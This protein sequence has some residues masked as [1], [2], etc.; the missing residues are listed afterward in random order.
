MAEA[1][2]LAHV[3]RPL[4]LAR[5]LDRQRYDRA[6]SGGTGSRQA[7]VRRRHAAAV[8]RRRFAPAARP[9][10]RRR[11]RRLPAV[12]VGQR[13][14]GRRAVRERDQRLL[15]S[16]R[17]AA[18]PGAGAAD[19][20]AAAAGAGGPAVPPGAAA[21]VRAAQRAPQSRAQRAR[22]TVA[23]RRPAARVHR[24]RPRAVCRHPADVPGQ[25][26]ARHARVHG[27]SALVARH[28]VAAMVAGL[29]GGPAAG[30]RDAGQ[31]G[32]WRRAAA[33]TAGAGVAAGA[34]DRGHGRRRQSRRDSRQCPR[35]RLL[36]RHGRR[37]A[38]ATGDLQRRQS[39]QPAGAG[40]RRAGT[41]HRRQSG[42]VP[43]HG[44]RAC[45][46]GRAAVAVG[47]AERAG[48]AP[49]AAGTASGCCFGPPLAPAPQRQPGKAQAHDGQRG[50]FR[51]GQRGKRLRRI[52][53]Q[54]R[55]R[56]GRGAIPHHGRCKERRHVGGARHL[57][58]ENGAGHDV[59]VVGVDVI[60]HEARIERAGADAA[61]RREAGVV[62]HQVA[63]QDDDAVA[64]GVAGRRAA[65]G[66]RGAGAV[67]GHGAVAVAGHGLAAARAGRDLVEI[68]GQVLHAGAD[69]ID[70]HRCRLRGRQREVG[71]GGRLGIDQL[72][73]AH[74][75]ADLE[76]LIEAGWRDDG[77][78]IAVGHSANHHLRAQF[79]EIGRGAAGAA[80]GQAGDEAGG[81][82]GVGDVGPQI[83][84]DAVVAGTGDIQADRG[85]GAGGERG[86]QR[87]RYQG[88]G[89]RGFV[90]FHV[91]SQSRR[92]SCAQPPRRH[93]APHFAGADHR[94]LDDHGTGGHDGIVADA[95]ARHDHGR[96]ANGDGVADYNR[97]QL[98]PF[99]LDHVG[100]NHGVVADDGVA[101]DA[102]E[103]RVEQ[104][105]GAVGIGAQPRAKRQS[106]NADMYTSTTPPSTSSTPRKSPS[107]NEPSSKIVA[108]TPSTRLSRSRVRNTTM[109]SGGMARMSRPGGD[110]QLAQGPPQRAR[111]G[112]LAGADAAHEDRC[113]PHRLAHQA[114]G[115]VRQ[116][117]GALL[118]AGRA[119]K[120]PAFAHVARKNQRRHLGLQLQVLRGGREP[121]AL[122]G[123]PGGKV[124]VGAVRVQRR[125]QH[126]VGRAGQ[127]G[128]QVHL[129]AR[130]QRARQPGVKKLD[131]APVVHDPA[132]QLGCHA[133]DA[134]R[135]VGHAVGAVVGIPFDHGLVHLVR[136][137]HGEPQLGIAEHQAGRGRALLALDPVHLVAGRQRGGQRRLFHGR[138]RPAAQRQAL[139]AA[140]QDEVGQRVLLQVRVVN[141]LDWR[142]STAGSDGRRDRRRNGRA[143]R[144]HARPGAGRRGSRSATA[145]CCRRWAPSGPARGSA[146]AGG[147]EGDRACRQTGRRPAAP[148]GSCSVPGHA[149]AR[150]QHGD[151][152]QR[153][154]VAA[155]TVRAREL[156]AVG[157]ELVAV[158]RGQD[159]A[160]VQQDLERLGGGRARA[161]LAA[162]DGGRPAPL[163]Q[164]DARRID[165]VIAVQAG[166][167]QPD[168]E[169]Q[170]LFAFGQR[171]PAKVFLERHLSGQEVEHGRAHAQR[172]G[173][174][175]GNVARRA[176]GKR[177]LARIEGKEIEAVHV[178]IHAEQEVQQIVVVDAVGETDDVDFG[179]DI[180]R[181]AHQDLGLGLAQ[182]GHGGAHL[183]VEIGHVEGI[184]IGHV[185]MA[186]AQAR[187][188]EQVHAAHTAEPGNGNALAAQDRLLGMGHPADVAGKGMLVGPSSGACFARDNGL[189]WRSRPASRHLGHGRRQHQR[190]FVDRGR[191]A[192]ARL[193]H[194]A[195]AEHQHAEHHDHEEAGQARIEVIVEDHLLHL[196]HRLGR[197]QD[198]A[199]VQRALVLGRVRQE[200]DFRI[201][202]EHLLPAGRQRAQQQPD[203]GHDG[204]PCIF[205]ALHLEQHAGAQHQCNRGQHLV[206]D[207]EQRPQGVDAA[208]RIDHALVQEVA[209]RRHAQAGRDQVGKRVFG[210]LHRRHERAQQVLQHEAAGAGAGVHGSE[211]EQRL[212]QDGKVVPE[213]HHA[214]A[215]D[216]VGQDVGH[217]DGQ[218]GRA[219]R[220]RDDAVFA[221]V[222]GGL[223]QHLGRH[224]KAPLRDCRCGGLGR[225][226][227]QCGR[228]VHGKVNAWLDG[229][230]GHQRHHGH[231]RFHQHGAVTDV[232][233]VHFV[234]NHLGR[235]ARSDQ[236][237]EAGH[238]AASDG[239]EQEREQGAR[240]H[241]AGTVD[242][243][244]H[245][246]HFQVRRDDNDAHRQ[247]D[248]G[249]DLEEGGQV[250]ARRQQQPHGQ[251]RGDKTVADQHPGQL[252][253]GE[254]E[255]GRER[256]MFLHVL[257]AQ[258]G[259]HQQHEADDRHFA[260]AAHAD[261]A[262]VHAHEQRDRDGGNHG[263]AAPRRVGQRFDHDQRQHGQDDHHDHEGAEQGD[264]AGNRAQFGFDQVAQ[265]AAVAPHRNEQHD[266][267]LH[268]A[269][270]HHAGQDP[271]HAGQVAH[272]RG[273]HGAD[274][275]TGA[276]NGGKVVAEQHVLVGGDVVEAVIEALRRRQAPGVE[277][278]HVPG[279]VQAVIAVGDQVHADRGNHD[280]DGADRFAALQ[281]DEAERASAQQCDDGPAQLGAE[282]L[283]QAHPRIAELWRRRLFLPVRHA[284]QR[285]DASA[286]ARIGRAKPV[287]D[288]GCAGPAHDPEPARTRPQRRRTG[289]LHVGQAVHPQTRRQARLR[290]RLAAMG[291]DDGHRHLSGR[292]RPG[293][294]AH[295]HPAVGQYPQHHA[296]D[297]ADRDCRRLRGSRR[298][299]GAERE[300]APGGG[301]QAQSAG[302]ARGGVAGRG[303]GAPPGTAAG[304][305][306]RVRTR[307]RPAQQRDGRGAPH[308]PQ[309]A[310]G[311]P[312][313]PGPGR[314]AAP[315]GPGVHPQFGNPGTLRDH[316][317]GGRTVGRGQY[318]AV[319]RG[320]GS[321][322]Q[323]RAPCRRHPHR[324]TPERRRA[325]RDRRCYRG[326]NTTHQ[327]RRQR[328][329][330]GKHRLAPPA[331][332]RPA[333]HDGTDGRHRRPV[334]HPVVHRRH[335][336][337]GPC[338]Q[339]QL[340]TMTT[341]IKILLVD[342]HPLVRD[343]L[344]AR[345]EAMPQFA[346]VAEASGAAEALEQAGRH[347]VDLVLMDINMRGPNGIEATARFKQAFPRIAVL[348]L[349]MH[350]KLEYV[351]Q[352]IQAGARGYVLKDAPG[353]DIV[354]AIETVMSGGIYYSAALAR[355]LAQPQSQDNQ[356]TSREHEVLRH[357]ANGESNKQ[358]AR[359]LD[360]SV[361]TVETHRLNI[362]RK[363]GIEGQ[364]ELIRFAVQHAQHLAQGCA[365]PAQDPGR[366]R[367]AR[368]ARPDRCR[369]CA[370]AAG[371]VAPVH[372]AAPPRDPARTGRSLRRSGGAKKARQ[373][374]RRRLPHHGGRRGR[375]LGRH[376]VRR[377]R[378][379]GGRVD[380]V[381]A[382]AGAGGPAGPAPGH[383][384]AQRGAHCRLRPGRLF[385]VHGRLCQPSR[386]RQRRRR[387]LAPAPAGAAGLAGARRRLARAGSAAQAGP[388]AVV[389]L[390]EAGEFGR[391]CAQLARAQLR[392]G[393]QRA[394]PAPAATLA[395]TAAVRAPA[396]RRPAQSA[397][398][399]GRRAR[400][401]D[402]SAGQGPG[403]RPRRPGHGVR[404]GRVLAA[405]RAAG[406][407]DDGNRG[408]P[409]PRP[410]RGDGPAGPR[411]TAGRTAQAGG[412]PRPRR[413]GPSGHRRRQ[414]LADAARCVPVGHPGQ[415][416]PVTD[417]YP[418]PVPSRRFPRPQRRA[419]RCRAALAG[420][421][422]GAGAGM[423]RA[424]RDR[425]S[426]GGVPAGRSRVAA[427]QAAG[428]RSARRQRRARAH[429]H[430]GHLRAA[431]ALAGAAQH[432]RL[433][434]G[435]SAAAAP[436][437]NP[438]PH[439]RIGGDDGH[440]RLYPQ[441]EQG[442]R[443]AV[444]LHV[445]GSGGPQHP[446]P[447][448]RR[449]HRFRGPPVA[450]AAVRR[451]QPF[452]GADRVSDRHHRAQ[453][454]RGAHPPPG[455][456]RCPDEPAQP[457]AAD[458]AGGPGPDGGPA[459]PAQ[460]LRTVHR[461]QPFQADQRHPG[462]QDRRRIIVRSGAPVPH[463]AARPGPGGAPGR[464]R[465]CRGPVRHRPALRGQHGRAKAAGHAQQ[466]DHHRRP[467]PARG[468][469]HRHQRLS[470]RRRR[471]RNPAAPGRH[472][473]VPRQAGSGHGQRRRPHHRR[474][475][476]GA[477]APPRARPGAA[478][479]IH[480][481]GRIDRAGGAS[482]GVGAG[483]GVRAG[484]AVEGCRTA[485]DPAGRQ[486]V[487]ARIH[488]VLAR[489]GGR[490]AQPLRPG[491]VVAG[492]GNHR[493]HADAQYRPRDRH[494]GPH[495]R[496]G[497]H[498]VARR[499][500]HRLLEPV[501]RPAA[502]AQGD[503][504]GR[505]NGG[506][507]GVPEE[508]GLRRG[509]GLSV[510][511]AA[512]SGRIHLHAELD[513]AR[514]ARRQ[515]RAGAGP[516]LLVA[517]VFHVDLPRGL[518]AQ[519][520]VD[521]PRA[522]AEQR[523]A[524]QERLVQ[525]V[526][527]T[528]AVVIRAAIDRQ[529]GH[530]VE[531]IR[532]KRAGRALRCIFGRLAI[533]GV[534]G[535]LELRVEQL[536][537]R[538]PRQLARELALR[539]NFQAPVMLRAIGHIVIVGIGVIAG[540]VDVEQRG[541]HQRAIGGQP[542]HAQFLLLAHARCQLDV[543]VA[544]T[545]GSRFAFFQAARGGRVPRQLRRHFINQRHH[546]RG[547]AH[548]V[549][550]GAL[551]APVRRMTHAQH[552]LPLRRKLD[553]VERIYALVARL[554][555]C[556]RGHRRLGG[557]HHARQGNGHRGVQVLRGDR[558][559]ALVNRVLRF[560]G[561]GHA[562][563]QLVPDRTCKNIAHDFGAQQVGTGHAVLHIARDAPGAGGQRGSIGQAKDRQRAV[564]RRFRMTRFHRH[565]PVVA[566][567]VVGAQLGIVG[568]RFKAGPVRA[569]QRF[570]ID[571]ARQ[572]DH[573]IDGGGQH[574]ARLFRHAALV[575][576]QVGLEQQAVRHAPVQR[577]R[578]E[579]AVAIADIVHIRTQ[580][581]A[582]SIETHAKLV[583]L[584]EASG[585]VGIGDHAAVLVH[586]HAHA[587]HGHAAGAPGDKVDHAGRR[588]KAVVQGG[589]ALEHFHALLVLH[590]HL[591]EVHDGHRAIEAVVGAVFHGNTANDQLI[592]RLAAVL[593]ARDAGRV[594]HRIVQAGHA[595]Q[596]DQL[597]RD[598]VDGGR[599]VHDVRTAEAAGLG[600]VGHQPVSARPGDLHCLQHLLVLL[601]LRQRDGGQASQGQGTGEQEVAGAAEWRH[602]WSGRG[603]DAWPSIP[604][605]MPI[606][607]TLRP[608]RATSQVVRRPRS[609]AGRPPQWEQS[610]A[611]GVQ[612][613]SRQVADGCDRPTKPSI[614]MDA[615]IQTY[616]SG[617][618]DISDGYN[619]NATRALAM[620]ILPAL[621]S[622]P[623]REISKQD[624]MDVLRRWCPTTW[625]MKTSPEMA[626]R[627]AARR[628]HTP[629]TAARSAA[630]YGNGRRGAL[631][632]SLRRAQRR[633]INSRNGYRDRGYE[634]RAGKV[635]LKIPKL[636]T[637]SYL[638]GFLEPR[639]TAEKAL[640]AVIQE[641]YIQ[642]ISTRSV[643]DLVK[644][645]G[646]TGVSKSQVSRLCEEIDERVQTFLNRPI[647][648][649]WPY[650][651]I[652]AAYV[653]SRQAGRVVSVAVIIAVAVNTDGVR[654]I[655]GVATG[656][657]EAEPFWTDFLR[658]L[659]R[660]GLR[661]VK[662]V[663]SDAHE[664]LKAAASKVLKT[665]WQRCRV[666]FIRNALAHAGKGQRQAVLAMINTIF[667]QDTAEAASVQWRS[668]ADQLQPKFPKL[669]AMM[670]D[671]EH[672]VLTLMTFPKA[673]RTQIHSTNPLE[674]LN[675][676]VERR[677]NVIRILPNDGAIIRFVGAMMLEQNNEWSLQR[678]YM[679]LEGLQS[680]SDNQPARLP[681]VIN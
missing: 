398:A 236:R 237:M 208:Q 252:G 338:R 393:H 310:P 350:D 616:W 567:R 540:T 53:F 442:R 328:L 220:T 506:A 109:C 67:A 274:Q 497:R 545:G 139:H 276:G 99:A 581:A 161:Q 445:R 597:A 167:R 341:P 514:R 609:D 404:G 453:D 655:L 454:G 446:V 84:V 491:A 196:R 364:A 82:A 140:R 490:H 538:L 145:G 638:P 25:R 302:A 280:P 630:T 633:R 542:A 467:G 19:G 295:R 213:C 102:R 120:H 424:Q 622:R 637:G 261:E 451:Q 38:R 434:P 652:D 528:R 318:R 153:M 11:D 607:G 192:G 380:D 559:V 377:P 62:E 345:L 558:V 461:P 435:G 92:G 182:R 119:G 575:V 670:D 402:G 457:H 452:G 269:R 455:L 629:G 69:R 115:L 654:E 18:L 148:R 573:A 110:D 324:D 527:G 40:G 443:T 369:A 407:A 322:H 268:G 634:T 195:D 648:G 131:T 315:P 561:A 599:H 238:G 401:P 4:A 293:A 209:P 383:P 57:V 330:C 175:G 319:P 55:Y 595:L 448:R 663:I 520:P 493:K 253:A 113:V 26:L 233:R 179:I 118:H 72:L 171:A 556:R 144:G 517:Q 596:V 589:S 363:L 371:T 657:S 468:R 68:N 291:L 351:S 32:P 30:V 178:Q 283:G 275:G 449:R 176:G 31:F 107:G 624:L 420:Q 357:I 515:P 524:A 334:R 188:R 460:R 104:G 373:R 579:L 154:A 422:A 353:K 484:Q 658:G 215:A 533:V 160:A 123:A 673:H 133:V 593:L 585:H 100:K 266:E 230:R 534:G 77:G 329:R 17:A 645:M 93:A 486:R 50:R 620:Y 359:A 164:V 5:T 331:R 308:F 270:K 342:D 488:G 222:L 566:E 588:R 205:A 150:Q 551:I 417:A 42:P 516:V 411:W 326:C 667:V 344:R 8:C 662:L 656:P 489:P 649:D 553:A 500:R 519:H 356:L 376:Q 147:R 668:V 117:G 463:R 136:L 20:A 462:P 23:G 580:R 128:D 612:K 576:L 372:A 346:V 58:L 423:H 260:D 444:R 200:T 587:G 281:G 456:L 332:H 394:G 621:G 246:R 181:H 211:D 478:R 508:L 531:R 361:R 114:F 537:R 405:G 157:V 87:S 325:G 227:D 554:Q 7:R 286:P 382:G 464:R 386:Q 367:H 244:G 632:G 529:A 35:G 403:R 678:R 76:G 471:R 340:K 522:R 41:G 74:H 80:H 482:G 594:A 250:I 259:A 9:A 14:S 323:H 391:V 311:H 97:L 665:S 572:R 672:E 251:H 348:I 384:H 546:R 249:A 390:A 39:H 204:H 257:A 186:D 509:A 374:G 635:D 512:G 247:A 146:R 379:D 387:H 600:R 388:V 642:G 368:A 494:H 143:Y 265:R 27:C 437:A 162:H 16:L 510:C 362:K 199:F 396:G 521:I 412:A 427:G 618:T 142:R 125:R 73:E 292:R 474:R 365:D 298:R 6:F 51:H 447:V 210:L 256:R 86:G 290:D 570:R 492:A 206:G 660:R 159:F 610:M 289:A 617:R 2:T 56:G 165:Q 354:V 241:R 187:Q 459:Q 428:G 429:A 126:E 389:P 124:V 327:R 381:A 170:R 239:D 228:A 219:A 664:G 611:P 231:E 285:P 15:E 255:Q 262:R 168:Q 647:E 48:R 419:V 163:L 590:R 337:D 450:V 155:G 94:I 185:K 598:H 320:A 677:T 70:V 583:P 627:K 505:G 309:S 525:I 544:R 619:A 343:G 661:G 116:P 480:P 248:D 312:G 498:A 418:V 138:E 552:A 557:K 177:G 355:Q 224:I 45:V 191:A 513:Q 21:G 439:P 214:L 410:G 52:H 278:Q 288:A 190:P 34:R 89:Q 66:R 477:L 152:L 569:D 273:Q 606:A 631:P 680:L 563:R 366:V 174:D 279:D 481:A 503:C 65:A 127:A 541:R 511:Q 466:P 399:A 98:Q 675:A 441:L 499:F 650:L 29:A 416:E 562:H 49:G 425:Q 385:L 604:S 409:Q 615:A 543:L 151:A 254:V 674:R 287:P 358:I 96:G 194:G 473:H 212:E 173:G 421:C 472:R 568:L 22:L 495:H 413:P 198:L 24:R 217:A 584:S 625:C 101:A 408:C 306:G 284:G 440:E 426:A 296:V 294:G 78:D 550:G 530:G 263:K 43:E 108:P 560:I 555:F 653:K 193:Q 571:R 234:F 526:D 105:A 121:E 59:E 574:D 644:A 202:M 91:C 375:R 303:A 158:R 172:R 592:P 111:L 47:P 565:G 223:H 628:F 36:A 300:R 216:H 137:G 267:V 44:R 430:P 476:A 307:G 641:A 432:P 636:R 659:T 282:G 122:H 626:F 33:H 134:Q 591:R 352:A 46:P 335:R 95:H 232:A 504:R 264:H 433:H 681:A 61:G 63:G 218:R 64:I 242:E 676:E 603:F 207:A 258:D 240:P 586:G 28:A 317:R 347:D 547:L 229:G 360:L 71:G 397:A 577:G 316:G 313:R 378:T 532:Q 414:L 651:W 85:A 415:P 226:A 103:R 470:A 314:R 483:S 349:S 602:G 90:C 184:E 79:G 436:V 271:Q 156:V 272:L 549:A 496:A 679:Q 535:V 666:H 487:R 201:G 75:L 277:T 130:R 54:E 243:L 501:H 305:H 197:G 406:H 601:R 479:R 12:A 141:E 132:H 189:P 613:R 129:Q 536:G 336:V 180:A 88:G 564:A 518:L 183:A 10:A 614:T 643:D 321:A 671:A 431:G 465:V 299:P 135:A 475:G 639:R 37:A 339:Q 169:A 669:A 370:S 646:M 1:V 3:G 438:R 112:R 392:P 221:H 623:V 83:G 507:A 485:A 502:Q 523:D 60:D 235:G 203:R 245:G 539:G 333:Q 608:T 395:A 605:L 400:R 81:E 301:R 548:V 578:H 13:A 582:G 106:R 166:R 469:Q 225:G 297:C 458:Q 304:C 149:P 640:T